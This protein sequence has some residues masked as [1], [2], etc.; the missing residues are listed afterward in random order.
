MLTNSCG[1]PILEGEDFASPSALKMIAEA[2][3]DR[4]IQQEQNLDYLER[5]EAAITKLPANQT[6]YATTAG[7]SINFSTMSYLSRYGAYAFSGISMDDNWRPGIYHIGGFVDAINAGVVNS[8]WA[9]IELYD[10]R[11]PR[12]LNSF[13]EFT[14][15][16]EATTGRGAIAL[17]LSQMVEIHDP[18]YCAISVKVNI[19]GAGNVTVLAYSKLWAHRI[20]GLSDV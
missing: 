4:F 8:M 19:V 2:A 14:R 13:T 20:R 16:A 10:R 17:G 7:T 9:D 11:G 15:S 1:F 6:C 12:L 3:D 5:P 18:F